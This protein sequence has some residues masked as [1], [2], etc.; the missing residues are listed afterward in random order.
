MRPNM[1][2]R[3][4]ILEQGPDV[5]VYAHAAQGSTFRVLV[6]H[7]ALRRRAEQAQRAHDPRSLAWYTK[8]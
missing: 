3:D 8:H 7:L 1:D 2:N 6:D 4:L 5:R